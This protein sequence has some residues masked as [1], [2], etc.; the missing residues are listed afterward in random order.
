MLSLQSFLKVGIWYYDD[1]S[2][3]SKLDN[4]SIV[5]LVIMFWC[6]ISRTD[7]SFSWKDL[8]AVVKLI[9]LVIELYYFTPI[10]PN[11]QEIEVHS[12]AEYFTI[13]QFL[14]LWT[15]DHAWPGNLETCEMHVNTPSIC[16]FTL[17]ATKFL[18]SAEW[19]DVQRCVNH[20]PSRSGAFW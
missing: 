5:T 2:V 11:S 17:W 4:N 19:Y 9:L 14:C 10:L 7:S 1:P 18:N 15:I 8:Y 3:L 6:L 16:I 13:L 12:R 20:I